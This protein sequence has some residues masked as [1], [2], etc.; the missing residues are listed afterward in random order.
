[1]YCKVSM[2]PCRRYEA[3][4]DC[5]EQRRLMQLPR[6]AVG[7]GLHPSLLILELQPMHAAVQSC[8]CHKPL[9]R[10]NDHT[11][12]LQLLLEMLRTEQCC[13][14]VQDLV[15]ELNQSSSWIKCYVSVGPQCLDMISQNQG[16]I[17]MTQEIGHW[18]RTHLLANHST[19]CCVGKIE[20]IEMADECCW[21]L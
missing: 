5:D 18:F 19:T 2:I 14:L 21:V 1:M 9:S 6:M 16:N 17:Y 20:I 3:A 12:P 8:A 7:I 13:K 11:L 15:R 4:N 10:L